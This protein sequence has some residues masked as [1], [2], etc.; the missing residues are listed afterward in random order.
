MQSRE[1]PPCP[2]TLPQGTWVG[3]FF[4]V[5]EAGGAEGTGWGGFPELPPTPKGGPE[6]SRCSGVENNVGFGELPPTSCSTAWGASRAAQIAERGLESPVPGLLL[7]SA[8]GE[9]GPQPHLW[10]LLPPPPPQTYPP[11][12]LGGGKSRAAAPRR[13]VGGCR[14]PDGHRRVPHPQ[15]PR[16]RAAALVRGGGGRSGGGLRL[17]L[18]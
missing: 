7:P 14:Q 11:R 16:L 9:Q 10:P 3:F 4:A 8:G 1:S 13:T 2:R 5:F 18:V 12:P 6:G 15:Q 17:G